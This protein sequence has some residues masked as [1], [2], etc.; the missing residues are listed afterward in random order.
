MKQLDFEFDFCFEGT[1]GDDEDGAEGA[2]AASPEENVAGGVSRSFWKE[3]SIFGDGGLDPAKQ[4]PAVGRFREEDR[5]S[6]T[7]KHFR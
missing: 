2:A 6:N 5:V 1:Y 4:G 3:R 7:V